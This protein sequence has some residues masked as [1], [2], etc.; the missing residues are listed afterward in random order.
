[1]FRLKMMTLRGDNSSPFQPYYGQKWKC[2][3]VTVKL[4]SRDPKKT[5]GSTTEEYL[6]RTL[7]GLGFVEG[8]DFIID[9]LDGTSE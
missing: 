3:G 9:Q 2:D 4:G 7:P 8:E 6:K 5:H 1:M